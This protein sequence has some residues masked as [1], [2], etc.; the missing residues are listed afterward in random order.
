MFV[1][2]IVKGALDMS[3]KLKIKPNLKQK[4]RYTEDEKRKLFTD[5]LIRQNRNV[6][7]SKKVYSRKVKNNKYCY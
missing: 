5:G 2:F 1:K 6:V 3:T 7:K 4:T